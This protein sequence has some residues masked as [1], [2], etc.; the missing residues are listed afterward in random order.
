MAEGAD[1]NKHGGNPP[2]FQKPGNV[3]HG[4]VAYGSGRDEQRHVHPFLFQEADPLRSGL[5]Q[6]PILGAGSDE[7]I[8]HRV[9]FAD[10]SFLLQ[11]SKAVQGKDDI[12]IGLGSADVILESCPRGSRREWRKAL[13]PLSRIL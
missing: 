4:H 5:L 3:S 7:G 11:F 1:G 13:A 2:F 8:S 12:G 6:Q 10:G 9:Q